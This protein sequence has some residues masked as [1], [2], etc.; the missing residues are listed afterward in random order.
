MLFGNMLNLDRCI[1]PPLEERPVS[2]RPLS[3]YASEM[4]A[5][6]KNLP[7][8]SAAELL[9]TYIYQLKSLILTKITCRDLLS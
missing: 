1:F 8:K 4:P 7:E 6:Q 3:L 5:M 2:I 9:R